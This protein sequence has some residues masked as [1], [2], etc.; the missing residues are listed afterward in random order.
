MKYTQWSISRSKIAWAALRKDA[1]R[2]CCCFARLD[3][4]HAVLLV[5]SIFCNTIFFIIT[6][7]LLWEKRYLWCHFLLKPIFLISLPN[8][9]L[10]ESLS[11]IRY[12]A[13][14]YARGRLSDR[15]VAMTTWAD[16]YFHSFH[17]DRGLIAYLLPVH[18]LVLYIALSIF[19][20]PSFWSHMTAA[21]MTF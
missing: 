17:T 2:P 5:F 7:L 20:G 12:Q 9:E 14:S 19:C 21:S 6:E 8:A 18:G 10:G 4:G 16:V 11:S 13:L 3:G 1:L 15:P